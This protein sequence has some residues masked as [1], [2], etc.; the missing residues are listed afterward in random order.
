MRGRPWQTRDFLAGGRTTVTLALS[1]VLIVGSLTLAGCILA[2]LGIQVLNLEFALS[3]AI[4]AGEESL[5]HVQFFP[6]KVN[7]KKQMVRISGRV[8]G[9]S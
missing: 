5:V 7:L 8:S 1:A 2:K 9:A 3:S 6:E 4:A